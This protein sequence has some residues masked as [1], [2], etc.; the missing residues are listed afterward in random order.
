MSV[1]NDME[2]EALFCSDLQPSQQPPPELVRETI[3]AVL[4]AVINPAEQVAQ[5]FGDHPE[6]AVTRMRWARIAA[7]EAFSFDLVEA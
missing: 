3:F 2:A 5:E 4:G 1:I 7:A 6:L